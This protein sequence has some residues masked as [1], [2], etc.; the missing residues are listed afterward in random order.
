MQNAAAVRASRE[1]CVDTGLMGGVIICDRRRPFRDPG[2]EDIVGRGDR[3]GDVA[4]EEGVCARGGAD[5][6][7]DGD[8][9]VGEGA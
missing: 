5:G 1:K 8:E 4:K 9:T 6:I 2:D 3:V 7:T